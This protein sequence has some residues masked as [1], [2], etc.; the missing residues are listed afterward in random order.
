MV[1]KCENTRAPN[2]RMVVHVYEHQLV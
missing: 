2:V 1:V